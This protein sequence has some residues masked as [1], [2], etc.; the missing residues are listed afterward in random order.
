MLEK[1][2]HLLDNGYN[3]EV[4]FKD[5][6]KAFDVLNHSLP[7]SKLDAYGFSLKSTTFIQSYLNKR[8]QKINVNDKFSAWEDIYSGVPQGSILGSFLFNI[9]INDIFSFLTTC[10]MCNYADDNTLYTY[11]R[12]FRQV[13]EYLKK[14]FEVLENWFHDN[15][16]V[17][18]PRK[19]EFMDFGK[20]N[21]S[22]VFTYHEI[23]FKKLLLRNCLVLQ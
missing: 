16:V 10:E 21:D 18:N 9:F 22:D 3:I 7:L 1:S 12:D 11:I 2:K 19:C 5:L 13:Q 4:L 17:L 6:S 15:Y 14:D 8:M 20:I 23:R